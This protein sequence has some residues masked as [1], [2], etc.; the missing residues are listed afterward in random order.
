MT[1]IGTNHLE[2][3]I[4]GISHLQL[5]SILQT[6]SNSERKA[7]LRILTIKNKDKSITPH[8]TL[9][10][11]LGPN[12]AVL[13]DSDKEPNILSI[14]RKSLKSI[15]PLISIILNHLL[16]IINLVRVLD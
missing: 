8:Y 12:L 16:K 15:L 4:Y 13:K 6:T 2:T 11:L 7:D 1:S 5:G 9:C 3:K 10:L 14:I